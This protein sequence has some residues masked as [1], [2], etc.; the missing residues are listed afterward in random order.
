MKVIYEAHVTSNG[1]RAAG[2][3]KSSDGLIDL[4]IAHPKEFGGP[5]G[6]ANPELLFAAGYSACFESAL[7]HVARL[8]KIPI[9]DTQV[10]A[11]IAIGNKEGGGFILAAR[12]E[13]SMNGVERDQKLALIEKAHQV[14]PYSNATRGN[15]EVKLEL[16]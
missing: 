2:H 7:L 10:V 12:L 5:G 1:G 11:H 15:M 13:I 6:A 8:A 3:V 14:C 9:T 4:K 16:V